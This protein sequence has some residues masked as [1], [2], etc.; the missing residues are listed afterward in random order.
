[1]AM[2][3]WPVP[4][5]AKT[6]SMALLIGCLTRRHY[7]CAQA[8]EIRAVR[9]RD[10]DVPGHGDRSGFGYA[11]HHQG[12]LRGGR[13]S[14]SPSPTAASRRMSSNQKLSRAGSRRGSAGCNE[15]PGLI[16]LSDPAATIPLP[17]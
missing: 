12:R 4:M 1:M 7:E 5:A 16:A 8:V 9:S 11:A 14:C 15:A 6:P 17:W 10:E 3:R 13:P 2:R